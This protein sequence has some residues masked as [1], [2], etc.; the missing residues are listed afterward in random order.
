MYRCVL[1]TIILNICRCLLF[2]SGDCHEPCQEKLA[3]NC[4]SL[5]LAEPLEWLKSQMKTDVQGKVGPS[6][7]FKALK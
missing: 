5:Y 6:Y 7:T 1:F 4:S 3:N 2:T